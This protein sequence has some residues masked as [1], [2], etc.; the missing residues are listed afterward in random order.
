MR[1]IVTTK[2]MTMIGTY[3]YVAV[4]ELSGEDWIGRRHSL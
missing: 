3:E 2:S 1:R 4:L